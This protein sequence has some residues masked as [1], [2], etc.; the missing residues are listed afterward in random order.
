MPEFTTDEDQS[1]TDKPTYNRRDV[2][3]YGSGITVTTLGATTHVSAEE[4]HD[5]DEVDDLGNPLENDTDDGATIFSIGLGQKETNIFSTRS[6]QKEINPDDP[7]NATIKASQYEWIPLDQEEFERDSFALRLSDDGGVDKSFRYE[8]DG[9]LTVDTV[10]RHDSGSGLAY[11]FNDQDSIQT[12]FRAFTNGIAG[13]GLFFRNVFGGNDIF[14]NQ[15]FQD[16]DWYRIRIVL[17]AE[18]NTYTV[19]IN[20]EEVAQTFYN[21]SGFVTSD[22]FR[23]MGRVTGSSTLIDYR[24]Y[25]WANQPILPGEADRI[26]SELLQYQLNEG[27]GT[28]IGNDPQPNELL[29]AVET[30][31]RLAEQIGETS[32]SIN[33]SERV[34]Q[35]LELLVDRVENGDLDEEIAVEAVQRMQIAENVTKATSAGLGPGVVDP[36]TSEALLIAP[37]TPPTQEDANV[38]G[39]SVRIGLRLLVSVVLG[40]LSIAD[41]SRKLAPGVAGKARVA[42]QKAQSLQS[43]IV[44]TIIGRVSDVARN[45]QT[46]GYDLARTVAEGF[47]QGTF[48]GGEQAAGFANDEFDGF[49][50]ATQRPLVSAFEG[51]TVG[52]DMEARLSEFDDTVTGGEDDDPTIRGDR[53][54]VREAAREGIRRVNETVEEAVENIEFLLQASSIAGYVGAVGAILTATGVFTLVGPV[55]TVSSAIFEIGLAFVGVVA[56]ATAL[57]DCVDIH[58]S[59]IDAIAGGESGVQL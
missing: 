46:R 28:G 50:A 13:N 56:G 16:G 39:R 5:Y 22:Q 27:D 9:D 48:E 21:G 58:E 26:D 2:L 18:E 15:N 51:S 17:N 52:P 49:Q 3:R 7:P 32:L 24:Y 44:D 6:E 31:Q 19:F 23:V 40:A 25:A 47:I 34:K 55:L 33:E 54:E 42:K 30:K 1:M 11:L 37:G 45:L 41:A 43:T 10:W 4:D 8:T 35:V 38:G 12:G 53:N 59:T 14:V 57:S 36:D 20:G 29:D